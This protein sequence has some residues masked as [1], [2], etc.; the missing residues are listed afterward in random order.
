MKKFDIETEV[1]VIV[2]SYEIEIS[3]IYT[4]Y[5]L[6]VEDCK[7]ENRKNLV[8]VKKNLK[9]KAYNDYVN[10]GFELYSVMI[11]CIKYFQKYIYR[12]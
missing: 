4:Y 2:K 9:P 1:W 7:E 8:D 3:E 10:S 5:D 6:A 12:Q 11:H